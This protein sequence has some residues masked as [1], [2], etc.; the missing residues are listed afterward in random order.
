MLGGNVGSLQPAAF[1]SMACIIVPID[2]KYRP[3]IHGALVAKMNELEGSS[4]ACCKAVWASLNAALEGIDR[5]ADGIA[6]RGFM[7]DLQRAG[8]LQPH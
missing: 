3:G 7:A 5:K 1:I 4:D 2:D 6:P 8:V